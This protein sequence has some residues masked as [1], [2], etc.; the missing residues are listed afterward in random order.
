MEMICRWDR[1]GN[2]VPFVFIEVG[3]TFTSKISIPDDAF[4][5]VGTPPLHSLEN[6]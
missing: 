1:D 6:K 2:G 4:I 3:M 5:V